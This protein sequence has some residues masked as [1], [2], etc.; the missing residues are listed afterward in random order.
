MITRTPLERWIAEKIGSKPEDLSRKSIERHQL[1]K[2]QE[3]LAWAE[4][5]SA[6]YKERLAGLDGPELRCLA[7]LCRLPFTTAEDV[8]R[9]PLPFL[10]VSQGEI[11]RVVTLRTSG[12]T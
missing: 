4:A 12:T 11:E 3:T 7:D 10:C 6:F 9:D 5:R 1:A 2:L 8:K